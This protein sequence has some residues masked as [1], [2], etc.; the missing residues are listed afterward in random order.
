MGQDSLR[1]TC[2]RPQDGPKTVSG[3]LR[4][5]QGPPQ[6][7]KTDQKLKG[8]PCVVLSR[9]FASDGLMSLE[10][11]PKRPKIAPRGPQDG[12]KSAP[13]A[14]QEGPKTTFLSLRRGDGN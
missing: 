7:A 14:A 5:L 9:S 1:H 13:R 11:A 2:K 10:M 8:N 3:A 12:P 6:E 4:S